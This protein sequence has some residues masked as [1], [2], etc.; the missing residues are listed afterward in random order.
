MINFVNVN[1][2]HVFFITLIFVAAINYENIF[3]MK[4]SLRVVRIAME[5]NFY[6]SVAYALKF[7]SYLQL[8]CIHIHNIIIMLNHTY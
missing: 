8:I 4:I 6:V 2:A 5:H 3:A 1:N 7:L